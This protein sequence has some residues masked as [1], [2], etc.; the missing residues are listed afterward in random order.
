MAAEQGNADAQMFLGTAYLKGR[1]VNQD[2]ANALLWLD[3][4]AKTLDGEDKAA[5]DALLDQA[6]WSASPDQLT[7]AQSLTA[8]WQPRPADRPPVV[9]LSGKSMARRRRY[10]ATLAN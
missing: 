10:Q 1:G 5:C 8:E 3:L 7:R 4:A 6:V 2:L 9:R